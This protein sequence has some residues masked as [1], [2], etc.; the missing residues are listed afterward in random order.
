MAPIKV[1]DSGDAGRVRRRFDL[2][3][4]SATDVDNSKLSR[5]GADDNSRTVASLDTE[6]CR[7]SAEDL[8]IIS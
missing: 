3:D 7:P 1:D 6:R 2:L 5:P 4:F 8:D